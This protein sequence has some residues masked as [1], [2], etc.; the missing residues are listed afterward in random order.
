MPFDDSQTHLDVEDS[1]PDLPD[2][3]CDLRLTL[4]EL[5]HVCLY[6]TESLPHAA[7]EDIT[8][9][10]IDEDFVCAVSDSVFED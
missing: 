9:F 8:R 6:S 4:D 5:D 2:D 7:D 10:A 1:S 3:R